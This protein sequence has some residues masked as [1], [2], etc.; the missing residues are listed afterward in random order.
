MLDGVCRHDRIRLPVVALGIACRHLY[1]TRRDAEIT[2]SIVNRV[3]GSQPRTERCARN[4]CPETCRS[5]IRRWRRQWIDRLRDGGDRIAIGETRRRSLRAH[6]DAARAVHIRG[7]RIVRTI[8]AAL[9]SRLDKEVALRDVE[10]AVDVVDVVVR[11][12]AHAEGRARDLRLEPRRTRIR[13]DE[14]VRRL[15]DIGDR[16][17]VHETRR[18]RR[19]IGAELRCAARIGRRAVLRTVDARL[20]ARMERQIARSDG[21]T[22]IVVGDVVVRR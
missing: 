16:V 12:L 5:C 9:V 6:V 13:R 20:V 11:R 18:R 1:L 10:A 8:G 21:E 2:I 7:E 14:G 17:A 3:V 19:G 22:A 4:P 15:R